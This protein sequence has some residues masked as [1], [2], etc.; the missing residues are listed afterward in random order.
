MSISN[1]DT[2]HPSLDMTKEKENWSGSIWNKPVMQPVEVHAAWNAMN[3]DDPL[4][5]EQIRCLIIGAEA[6]MKRRLAEDP[7]VMSIVE[8]MHFASKRYNP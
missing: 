6:K 2:K 8:E 3:P 5:Y 4:S 1:N 7:I